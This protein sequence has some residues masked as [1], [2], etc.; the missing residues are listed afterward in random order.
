MTS[1]RNKALETITPVRKA[2]NLPENQVEGD[3]FH[4]DSIELRRRTYSNPVTAQSESGAP[5]R[6][7]LRHSTIDFGYPQ[8]G[9]P[10]R[11]QSSPGPRDN[12][13]EINL[14]P[15]SACLLAEAKSKISTSENTMTSPFPRQLR[16]ASEILSLRQSLPSHFQEIPPPSMPAEPITIAKDEIAG[17]S[18]SPSQDASPKNPCP[19]F[20]SHTS[21]AS[22]FCDSLHYCA[23][24][25]LPSAHPRSSPPQRRPLLAHPFSASA[26]TSMDAE[27]YDVI[28]PLKP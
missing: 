18:Q 9:S 4:P 2:Q 20:S 23:I 28:P 24:P 6:S 13:T 5:T 22:G 15:I 11:T 12:Q 1:R 17:A 27:Q 21:P 10:T 26:R 16:V 7:Q 14:S 19:L 3:K 25:P 8:Q